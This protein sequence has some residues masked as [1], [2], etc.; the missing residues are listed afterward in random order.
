MGNLALGLHYCM[1][2]Y[3][4]TIFFDYI[5]YTVMLPVLGGLAAALERTADAEIQRIQAVPPP[6][7]MTPD[8]FHRFMGNRTPR[9]PANVL[10][11]F[12]S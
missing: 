10:N 4:V 8:A 7:T 3:A 12:L 5:A 9:T 6:V 2:I 1:I 11:S